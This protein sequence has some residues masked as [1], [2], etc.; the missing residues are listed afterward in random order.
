MSPRLTRLRQG[1]ALAKKIDTDEGAGATIYG[2]VA[3]RKS[4][5]L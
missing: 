2:T 4:R 1:Y 3:E 5:D